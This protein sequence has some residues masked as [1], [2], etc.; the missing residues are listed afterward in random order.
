VAVELLLQHPVRVGVDVVVAVVRV[1]FE[2]RVEVRV[3]CSE[4]KKVRKGW[5]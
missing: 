5:V 2:K 4:K 1:G 3:A